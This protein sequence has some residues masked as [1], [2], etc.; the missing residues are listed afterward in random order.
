MGMRCWD[1]RVVF[2][3][4]DADPNCHWWGIHKTYYGRDGLV[5]GWS[6][7]AMSAIAAPDEMSRHGEPSA[8]QVMA[9][10]LTRMSIALKREAVVESEEHAKV[11]GE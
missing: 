9:R 4:T 2:H 6:E 7:D 11:R 5:E 8:R 1:F 3:D 10:I